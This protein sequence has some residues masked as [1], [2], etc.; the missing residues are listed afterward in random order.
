L[1]SVHNENISLTATFYQ[2]HQKPI[3][4]RSIYCFDDTQSTKQHQVLLN[5]FA[6]V[7][8][9]T[10]FFVNYMYTFC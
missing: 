9:F 2:Y 7:N 10:V 3:K 6:I 8:L 5:T 4:Y 1:Y